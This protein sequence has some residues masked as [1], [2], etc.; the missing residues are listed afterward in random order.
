MTRK[1]AIAGALAL[2][3]AGGSHAW[4]QPFES[5]PPG[6]VVGTSQ[7]GARV[8]G[9]VRLNTPRVPNARVFGDTVEERA[10]GRDYD[11]SHLRP[12][13][14]RATADTPIELR[15]REGSSRLDSGRAGSFAREGPR[16]IGGSS[17]TRP[18]LGARRIGR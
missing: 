3:A 2:L 4:A 7:S 18:A 11:D 12:R 9:A 8:G 16:A 14:P 5:G 15:A 6:T 17:V 1:W 13:V 10:W